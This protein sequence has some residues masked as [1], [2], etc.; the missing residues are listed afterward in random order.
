MSDLCIRP[1]EERDIA[2][3]CA[4]LK[5]YAEKKIVLP[6]DEAD[7]RFYLKNFIVAE[8][9]GEPVGCVAFRSFGNDLYEVRSLVV[10]PS[11]Q[12]SGIG[13]AMLEWKLE[14]FRKTGKLIRLFSLT[15]VPEFFY[16]L[17]FVQTT[18]EDFPEKIW[19]DCSKCPKLHCC[20]EVAV[21]YLI[22]G[23]AR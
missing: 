12:R 6:R 14:Q 16:R 21:L 15:V 10:D 18:K 3:I 7:I 8:R 1:A 4:W 20:D 17:G 5:I 23:D 11:I 13:K 2:A 22:N 9:D 19:S